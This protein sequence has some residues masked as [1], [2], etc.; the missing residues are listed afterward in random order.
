MS[1]RYRIGWPAAL[2]LLHLL[3]ATL[4]SDSLPILEGPDE[5]DHIGDI[6]YIVTNDHLPAL[7]PDTPLE[8]HQPPLYYLLGSLIAE[9]NPRI[10]VATFPFK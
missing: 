7:G 8:S 5:H 1:V 4:Y 3:L 9:P 6:E 10:F 2:A